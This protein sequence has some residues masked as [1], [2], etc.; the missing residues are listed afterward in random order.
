M[1]KIKVGRKAPL[2]QT[3]GVGEV[4]LFRFEEDAAFECPPNSPTIDALIINKNVT[5][6]GWLIASFTPKLPVYEQAYKE[7]VKRF[8]EPVYQSP[9]RV[10]AR[11][12]NKFFFCIFDAKGK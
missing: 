5:G 2:V 3:C 10:N 6:C 12:D 7:M 4:G 8:G 1:S 9:V 11:T